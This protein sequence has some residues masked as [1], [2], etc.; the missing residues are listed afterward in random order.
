MPRGLYDVTVSVG[1]SGRT[2]KNN[3]ISVNGIQFFNVEQT[4]ASV[5]YMN[6]TKQVYCYS[7]KL[8]LEMGDGK[9]YTMLNYM[10]IKANKT[11]I[12][13][14]YFPRQMTAEPKL[15]QVFENNESLNMDSSES[16]SRLKD[17]AKSWLDQ[18]NKH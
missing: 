5:S 15:L 7:N 8:F 4:N 18:H 1:W 2:Y 13:F 12:G 16:I 14:N 17:Q 6:R 11:D 3:T 9:D 10:T